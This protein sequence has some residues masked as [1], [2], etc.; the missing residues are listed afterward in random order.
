[1]RQHIRHFFAV[2]RSL[3][4]RFL[5]F[6][7]SRRPAHSISVALNPASSTVLCISSAGKSVVTVNALSGSFKSIDQSPGETIRFNFAPMAVI[8]PPHF[9]FVLNFNTA[10]IFTFYDSYIFLV[11]SSFSY[12]INFNRKLFNTTDTELKAIAALANIGFSSKPFTGNNT[13]A[14]SG[15]PIRL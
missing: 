3:L 9:A 12:F 2:E 13:P 10:I 4:Q 11:F 1:M 14:A 8:Q 7:K 6:H 15:I 5:S